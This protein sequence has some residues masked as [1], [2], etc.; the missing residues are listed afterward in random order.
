MAYCSAT[1]VNNYLIGYNASDTATASVISDSIDD[2][3]NEINKY[4]C[5][6]YDITAWST[7]TSTPPTVGTICKWLAAG[8][9]IEAVSRGSKE[10]LK[11][12][13]VLIK[14]AMDNL[15]K[16]SKGEL[17]LVDSSG[18]EIEES[19]SATDVFSTTE[20]YSNTFNEDDNLRWKV[21]ADK[22]TDIQ[23]ERS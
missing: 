20:N 23:S 19:N 2:A 5:N 15:E 17:D 16:L 12:S 10:Q 6:R 1:S 3:T 4:L 9:S 21:D 14:R 11:R 7:L 18:V 22:L 8:Y 13:D